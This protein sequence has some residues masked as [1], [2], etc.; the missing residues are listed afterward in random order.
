MITI[1]NS[2]EEELLDNFKQF[3]LSEQ[4]PAIFEPEYVAANEADIDDDS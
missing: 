2:Q 3:L 4:I 1:S